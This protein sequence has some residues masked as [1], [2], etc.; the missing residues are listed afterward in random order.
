VN[1]AVLARLRQLE[2]AIAFRQRQ[3]AQHPAEVPDDRAELRQRYQELARGADA[4]DPALDGLTAQQLLD[5]FRRLID[6]PK[7]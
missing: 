4:R 5:R 6:V 3:G 1:G 2:S 7:R